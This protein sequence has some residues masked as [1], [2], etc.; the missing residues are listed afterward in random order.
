M[1]TLKKAALILAGLFAAYLLFGWLALPQI[2]QSQAQ[3]Y[4]AEKTGHRLTLDR[5]VFDPFALS[6]RIANLRLEEPDG[7]PLFA[8]RELLVDLSSASLF[9]R[10]V[11][12]DRIRLDAPEVTAV[13]RGDGR[14]NWTA[15]AE[16]LKS[17]EDKPDSPLPRLDIHSFE[18]AGGRVDFADERADFST[19]IEPLDLTLNELSTLPDDKGSYQVSAQTAIGA[20]VHWRGDV[21]LNPIAATGSLALEDLD[22]ARLAPY[23]ERALPAAQAQGKLAAS[24]GY[25]AGYAN[26]RLD[27]N[28]DRIALKLE[29]LRID[30]AQTGTPSFEA[31]A[32]EL[33]NGRYD[34]GPNRV[35]FDAFSL[36]GGRAALPRPGGEPVRARLGGLTLEQATLDLAARKFAVGRIALADGRLEATRD[37]RGRI[38]V[39]EAV[40]AMTQSFA[41]GRVQAAT[42]DPA[43]P[44]AQPWRY[45]VDVLALTGFAAVLRDQG[46]SPAAVLAFD[47]IG[48]AVDGIS[49]QLDAPLPIRASL[50]VRSGGAFEAEGKIVPATPSAELRVKLADLALA[51]AQPYLASVARLR[52]TDGRL[53]AD[54]RASYGKRG[55]EFAGGFALRDLRLLETDT[56]NV[57]LAWK[58]LGTRSLRATPSQL[59]IRE[60]ALDG[61]DAKLLIE[62]DKSVNL[63]RVLRK[64]EPAPG[65]AK[66]ASPARA[67]APAQASTPGYTV[68]IERLKIDRGA[69]DFADLS[70]ALPFG[71]RIHDLHGAVQGVSSRPGR[72]AQVELDGQVDDYGL[73][74]AVGQIDLFDPTARTDL[75]VVFR[76]VEMT[77]LT[78]YSATFAGRKIDSGKL[79]LDLEYK[80]DRRQ[81]SGDNQIVMDQLTLGERVENPEARNLPLDLAI[82]ILQD[83]DGRIDLGLPVSGSLDD[84]EFSYG[85]IIW[86]AIL[87]LIGKIATAPFRALGALFGG[88]G[89]PFENIVFDAGDAALTPP[90]RE[91]LVRLAA[92]LGKRPRLSLTVHG[93]YADSD[94]SALQDRQA[95]RAVA[96]RA[97]R[98]VAAD[99]DPGPL[100][101]DAPEVKS[102]LENLYA[103]RVGAGDLAALREGFRKANPG[104]P[105]ERVPG[106]M[107]SRLSG[108]LRE[109]RTLSEEETASLKGTDFH[110]LLFARLRDSESVSDAQLQAL[111]RARGDAATQILRQ[112]GAA[113]DRLI[114]GAP[115]K[116]EGKDGQVPVK[117]A[118]GAS[119]GP[120][121]EPVAEPPVATPAPQ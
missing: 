53:S 12:F 107:L 36:A 86:K 22:L 75:K 112:A 13:M 45:R 71:A 35:D 83:A 3:S 32:I 89:E 6:L 80:I 59:G 54:G 96:L 31:D 90:E 15:L 41:G 104:Q 108:L 72:P 82:A 16:A 121:G 113:V 73:A 7:K 33:R 106:T 74:R 40:Q 51:P 111:A 95:R 46:V 110:A 77:R 57:F 68:D 5:P 85:R 21:T 99:A 17:K 103:E 69:L 60:L 93:V 120:A 66:T 105:E 76:N 79:S 43:R 2:L 11:V 117:L 10:A 88:A 42:P 23:L 30:L 8:F 97:G 4:I 64:A 115:E 102:A 37:A 26:G 49:D 87:N 70:L 18:L 50:R 61:L 118:L 1:S 119:P 34:L 62:K 29:K 47:D 55:A 9:R 114:G 24:A 98:Q 20:R 27:L 52:L 58:S 63:T 94:R 84:P 100:S 109:R 116:V 28:L 78:P 92:A 65:A 56:G 44:A 38:D 19:R 39:A 25:R 81:L 14:F 101:T 67:L 91:K 48:V